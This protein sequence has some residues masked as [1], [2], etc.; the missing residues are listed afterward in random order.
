MRCNVVMSTAPPCGRCCSRRVSEKRMPPPA[1]RHKGQTAALPPSVSAGMSSPEP[2]AQARGIADRDGV[3]SIKVRSSC[4]EGRRVLVLDA[5]CNCTVF[6]LKRLLCQ[7]PHFMC[8]HYSRLLLVFKGSRAARLRRHASRLRPRHSAAQRRGGR[9]R[10]QRASARGARCNCGNSRVLLP[11][12][13]IT[14]KPRLLFPHRNPV[15]RLALSRNYHSLPTPACRIVTASACC[16]HL[17]PPSHVQHQP[18]VGRH[19][20]G[21]T[22]TP[23][24]PTPRRPLT[25]PLWRTAGRRPTVQHGLPAAARAGLRVR[26]EQ[27]PA[28]SCRIPVVSQC[29]PTSA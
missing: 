9:R 21:R 3:T 5:P 2:P 4:G 12:F 25:S 10:I 8:S 16:M 27:R 15:A 17:P 1:F 11:S 23:P 7:Q 14:C 26:G 28:A 18:A 29:P 6:E 20:A 19:R 24:A 13:P 22:P